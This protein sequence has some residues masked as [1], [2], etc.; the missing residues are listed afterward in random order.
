M[1]DSARP[2]FLR[3]GWDADECFNFALFEERD[4]LGRGSSQEFDITRKSD[5]P[6]KD[7]DQLRKATTDTPYRDPLAPEIAD[8][9]HSITPKDFYA[10]RVHASEHNHWIARV[11]SSDE[12]KRVVQVEIDLTH[13]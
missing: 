13:C 6:E 8:R 1:T 5:L 2:N 3:L 12:T 11:Q 10:A 9:S 4:R 7:S